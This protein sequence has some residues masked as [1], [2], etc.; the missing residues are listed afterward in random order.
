MLTDTQ[1]TR[2]RFIRCLL[3]NK[4]TPWMIVL[5]DKLIV[6][7]VFNKFPLFTESIG[8]LPCPQEPATD[9]YVKSAKCTGSSLDGAALERNNAL[10]VGLT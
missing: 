6:V 1:R 10:W 7:H 8:S 2:W 9:P 3:I 4:L 5:F